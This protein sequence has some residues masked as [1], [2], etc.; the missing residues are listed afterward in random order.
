MHSFLFGTD[1]SLN[2]KDNIGVTAFT[3]NENIKLAKSKGFKGIFATNTNPLIQHFD[4]R[5]FG[6]ENM[7]EVQVNKYVD[8]KGNRPFQRAS[9]LQTAV[10]MYKKFD[11]ED[12]LE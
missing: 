12:D 10:V 1:E 4:I 9:D 5:V 7:A 3:E 6:Y 2:C 8:Q 11:V